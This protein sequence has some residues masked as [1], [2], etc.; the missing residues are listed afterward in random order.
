MRISVIGGGVVPPETEGVA[1]AVGRVIGERGHVLICGGRGGVMVAA[2][3][4]AKEAGGRTIGI[5][6]GN[7]PRA[8]NDHLDCAIATGMGDARNALVALNGDAA[9]AID[10]AMGT[11]S[12]IAL[13]L[14]DGKPVA[15]LGTHDVPGVEAVDTPEEAVAYVEE[16]SQR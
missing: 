9:I 4:G 16:A 8:G 2:C 12:E 10:G 15:G 11:L 5:L 6:P 3:R 1:E 13:V 14:N 7:D